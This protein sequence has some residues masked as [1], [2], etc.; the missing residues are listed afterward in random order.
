MVSLRF[1]K[2]NL[3]SLQ[4]IFKCK[5]N[6]TTKKNAKIKKKVFKVVDNQDHKFFHCLHSLEI[7]LKGK[8][9]PLP[10]I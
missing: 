4:D 8:F 6:G 2:L 3:K 9:S 10:I 7:P 1:S 5:T